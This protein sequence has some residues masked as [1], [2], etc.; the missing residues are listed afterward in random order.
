M[1]ALFDPE[2]ATQA[3]IDSLGPE[4]LAKAAA[5]TAG[6]HWLTLWELLVSALITLL[7]VRMG[8]LEKVSSKVPEHRHWL[9]ALLTSVVFSFVYSLLNLPWEYVSEFLRETRYGRTSQPAGD[10]LQQAV[11]S[12]GTSVTF[13]SLFFSG[14]YWFIRR[15][16]RGWWLWASGFTMAMAGLMLILSP[17][18]IE[19]LFNDYTAVPKGEVRNALEAMADEAGIERER[20]FMYDGSRQSNNFTANVSGLGSA[21]RIAISDVAIDR[22]LLDEV[23][24]V[25]GHE[26]GHYVLGHVWRMLFA[27]SALALLSFF[28][29]DRFFDCF[30]RLFGSKARLSD[31][32]GLP[33]FLFMLGL[34]FTLVQPV[35]NGVIRAGENAADQYSL[36]TVNLPDALAGALVKTAEYRYPRPS[37]LQE[38]LFYS[39]PSVEKRVRRAMEWKQNHTKNQAENSN[40]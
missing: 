26:I 7:I 9:N 4:A 1:S 20:I 37:P 22:A 6:A 40:E 3:Y 14:L 17:T 10:W 18:F 19:P 28:L 8:V 34:V 30:A 11:L 35:T 12:I 31:P 29:I 2:L 32:A 33:V 24:A 25:T 15:T 39:H 27:L 38:M 36:E 21:A 5:Y 13:G 23:K 16:G